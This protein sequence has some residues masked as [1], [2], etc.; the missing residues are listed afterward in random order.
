[1]AAQFEEAVRHS[2]TVEAEQFRPDSGEDL[3]RRGAGRDVV[4]GDGRPGG[5]GVRGGQR[6]AV[7][8]AAG[9]EGQAGHLDDDRR[10][11]VL[12]KGAAEEVAQLAGVR[13]S[14]PRVGGH[15]VRHQVPVLLRAA[16]DH[17][18]RRDGGMRP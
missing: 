1:M 3:L 17:H 5:G 7:D 8:L 9:G 16:G 2:D 14:P 4:P 10:D 12:G 13:E 11:Q 18:G 15:R 6:G